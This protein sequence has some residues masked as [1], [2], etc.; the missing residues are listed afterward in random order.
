MIHEFYIEGYGCSLNISE[1]E[2]IAGFLSANGYKKTLNPSKADFLIINTCAVKDTT[3]KRMLSRLKKMLNIKKPSAKL[4][5]FGCL[6]ST[7]KK[8]IQNISPKIIVLNTKLSSLAKELCLPVKDFSPSIKETKSRSLTSIIPISTGC[9]GSCTYCITK[10][11]RGELESYSEESIICAFKRALKSSKEIYLTSQD[12][13]AYGL[14]N[15]SSLP[16]L[17]K[18]LLE[19]KGDYFIRL[20]MMNPNHF[21]KIRKELLPLL[22]DSRMY[23][24]LHLPLQSGS[25][26]ILKKMNR[27][28]NVKEFINCVE[29][30]RKQCPNIT[31]ATD[32]I[33]GFPGE[34]EKDFQSTLRVLKKIKP[35]VINISRFGKRPGTIATK[36]SFQLTEKIKKD[37][38]RR[39]TTFCKKLFLRENQKFVGKTVRALVSERSSTNSELLTART[40]NYKPIIVDT[41][42]GSFVRVKI[43]SAEPNFFK[44]KVISITSKNPLPKPNN[45]FFKH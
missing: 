36:F 45:E 7:R 16:N 20:G 15:G 21:I 18:K 2:K 13:G 30:A 10:L 31:V 39:L 42:F 5:A 33:V 44:G 26:S 12:L 23:K 27:F 19:T 38:S 32:I 14:D 43:T 6:A 4:I 22:N 3:E 34:N 17:L 1:T 41:G 40:D 11:A 8:A 9:V 35:S 37:K 24:F 29:Y 28:Y 25:D